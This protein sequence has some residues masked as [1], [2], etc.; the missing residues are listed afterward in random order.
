MYSLSEALRQSPDQG[1][2]IH[3][4]QNRSEMLCHKQT[5]V[6]KRLVRLRERN[7]VLGEECKGPLITL[8][9]SVRQDF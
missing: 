5:Q 1:H 8:E 9:A 7:L 4:L 3:G 6:L 2:D